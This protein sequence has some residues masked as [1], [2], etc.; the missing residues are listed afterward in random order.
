MPSGR[1]I[2]ETLLGARGLDGRRHVAHIRLPRERR[3]ATCSAV[4]SPCIYIIP[5]WCGPNLESLASDVTTSFSRDRAAIALSPSQAR[6]R[7]E[8]SLQTTIENVCQHDSRRGKPAEAL[9]VGRALPC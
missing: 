3:L 9:S 2:A 4:L 5:G 6:D 1:P 8:A 7:R